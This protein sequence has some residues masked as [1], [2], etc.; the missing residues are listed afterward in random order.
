MPDP[1]PANDN[2]WFTEIFDF[3]GFVSQPHTLNPLYP[4]ARRVLGN[5]PEFMDEYV[6]DAFQVGSPGKTRAK[7]LIVPPNT[8]AVIVLA[9]GAYQMLGPGRYRVSKIL[10][11][12]RAISVHFINTQE[13]GFR[14]E[15]F[16]I[17][18]QDH[19]ITGMDVQLAVQVNTADVLQSKEKAEALLQWADPK[20]AIRGAVTKELIVQL[21][22]LTHEEAMRTL[23]T[24]VADSAAK[25]LQPFFNNHGLLLKGF[26]L[27]RLQP[28][29]VEQKAALNRRQKQLDFMLRLLEIENEHK[30]KLQ[31]LEARGAIVDLNSEIQRREAQADEDVAALKQPARRREVAGKLVG[32]ARERN[33]A[34]R[35]DAIEA[36]SDIAKALMEEMHKH[37]GRTYTTQDMQPLLKALELL[38]KLTFAD[39]YKPPKVPQQVRSFFAVDEDQPLPPPVHLPDGPLP[40]KKGSVWDKS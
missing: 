29:E 38:D 24:T 36:V 22:K 32:E 23:A 39:D 16:E 14:F 18:S 34:A 9:D 17:Y 35:M 28:A 33:Q 15:D 10:H 40:V 37:P 25:A 30:T 13:R 1:L 11:R 7:N 3:N 4:T 19:L 2:A 20:A 8:L 21:S 27:T 12:Q 5:V 6:G 26:L 31:E